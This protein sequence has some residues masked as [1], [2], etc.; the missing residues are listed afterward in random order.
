MY[1]LTLRKQNTLNGRQLKNIAGKV[2]LFEDGVALVE[3]EYIYEAAKRYRYIDS[4][5]KLEPEVVADVQE[6]SPEQ[7]VPSLDDYQ[8]DNDVV[9]AEVEV[10]TETTVAEPAET[11]AAEV[12]VEVETETADDESE[13]DAGDDGE[14]DKDDPTAENDVARLYEELGTWTAVAERLEISTAALRKLRE[15]QGLI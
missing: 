7:D 6:E 10:E 8:E 11:E 5:R 13:T 15:E 1:E 2:V 14:S 12:E 4:R 9:P 3:D